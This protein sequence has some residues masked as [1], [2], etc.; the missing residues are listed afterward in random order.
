MNSWCTEETSPRPSGSPI[1][2]DSVHSSV[3]P[4]TEH[5]VCPVQTQVT[6]HIYTHFDSQARQFNHPS[7]EGGTFPVPLFI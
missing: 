3:F 1:K 4:L 6:A 7:W 2:A 5:G